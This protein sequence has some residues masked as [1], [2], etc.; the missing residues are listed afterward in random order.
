MNAPFTLVTVW[1]IAGAGAVAGSIVG[2]AA[3]KPGLVAGALVG[4]Y[5]MRPR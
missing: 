4:A 1:L 2:N 3:G 5:L